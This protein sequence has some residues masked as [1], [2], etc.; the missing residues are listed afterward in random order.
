MKYQIKDIVEIQIGYQSRGKITPDSKGDFRIIQMKD[1]ND[2]YV[3]EVKSISTFKPERDPNKYL[4]RLGDVLFLSRGRYNF[5]YT[6]EEPM[7]NT[8]FAS[9]FYNLRLTIDGVLPEY[10]GWYLNSPVAQSTLQ[11]KSRGSNIP[12]I[13]RASF[14]EVEVE[15]PPVTVQKKIVALATLQK[16]EQELTSSLLKKR[17]QLVDAVCNNSVKEHSIALKGEK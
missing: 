10:L 9:Y 6:I 4:V 11:S 15:V 13:P 17:K 14:E 5:G 2:K 16:K 3:L 7:P 12:Y 8:L 1:F